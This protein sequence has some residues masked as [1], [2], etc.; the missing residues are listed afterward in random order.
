MSRAWV[1]SF[2]LCH[3]ADLIEK[4]SIAQE[5]ARLEIPRPFLNETTDGRQEHLR[6]MKA[7]LA[8]DLEEIGLSEGR[9]VGKR[10]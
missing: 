9:I 3:R 8:F 2:I 7:E 4:K 6:G 5:N 10:R 1:D